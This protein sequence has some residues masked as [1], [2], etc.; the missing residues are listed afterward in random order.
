[1]LDRM[2][3]TEI[4]EWRAFFSIEASE[5]ESRSPGSAGSDTI[6][7]RTLGGKSKVG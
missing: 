2:S 7:V 1:M 3:S 4:T 5:M 6:E